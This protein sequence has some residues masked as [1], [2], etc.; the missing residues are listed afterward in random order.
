MAMFHNRV[1]AMYLKLQNNKVILNS[2]EEIR[3]NLNLPAEIETIPKC[4]WKLKEL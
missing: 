2:D 1:F 4:I 3:S